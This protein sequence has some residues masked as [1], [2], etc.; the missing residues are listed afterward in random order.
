MAIKKTTLSTAAIKNSAAGHNL[1]ITP[2]DQKEL[3]K[4]GVTNKNFTAIENLA[5]SWLTDAEVLRRHG[6]TEMANIM[7]Q[8]A[9][10]LAAAVK[11]MGK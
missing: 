4:W 9:A 10:E 8:H 1:N 11:A 2:F 6:Q 5:S 7:K 3:Q